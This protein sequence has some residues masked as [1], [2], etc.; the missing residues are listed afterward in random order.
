MIRFAHHDKV[1]MDFLGVEIKTIES[2]LFGAEPMPAN[3]IP[4]SSTKYAI[5][6]RKTIMTKAN[7]S[8]VAAWSAKTLVNTTRAHICVNIATPIRVRRL[9]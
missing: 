8:S 6:K 5:K 4:L 3:A 9:L 2:S 7:V 1:L